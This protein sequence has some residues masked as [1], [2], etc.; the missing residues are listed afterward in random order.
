MRVALTV[1]ACAGLVGCATHPSTDSGVP[2]PKDGLVS[3]TL[4]AV[5]QLQRNATL[6]AQYEQMAEVDAEHYDAQSLCDREQVVGTRISRNRC[7]HITPA[8]QALLKAQLEY[9]FQYSRRAAELAEL[10]RG[11][12]AYDRAQRAND[13]PVQRR[14]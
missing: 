8:E 3:L 1:F 13:R 5:A 6:Q 10:D 9:E 12:R 14:R 7:Y 2:V 11:Q 4:E